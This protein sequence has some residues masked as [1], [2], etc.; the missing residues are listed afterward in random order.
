MLHCGWRGLAGGI[1]DRGVEAVAATGR[2]D[3]ARDRALLLRG[4]RRGARRFLPLGEGV[5]ERTHARPRPRSP[6][7]LLERAG[8]TEIEIGRPLHELRG[9]ALLLPPPRAAP[10]PGG[11]REGSCGGPDPRPRGRQDPRQPRPGPR[12]RRDRGGDPRRDQ[13]RAARGDGRA[14]GGRASRSSARTACRTSRQSGSAGAT[15]FEWD[16][17]G[18]LQSRKVKRILPLVRLIHSVASDSALEQLGRH[19]DPDTEVLVEVNLAGEE[20]EG[21]GRAGRARRRSSSAARSGSAGLMTMPPFSE[22][23]EASRPLFR[24]PRRARRPSTGSIGSR[25]ARARIGRSR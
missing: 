13:V 19:A 9:G 12:A 8:V 5:A 22:D 7:R 2:C 14:R 15:T 11:A 20:V 6:G 23:P 4:R 3:R 16:F 1:V 10:T 21:R 17:I 24:P 25:W 18:N